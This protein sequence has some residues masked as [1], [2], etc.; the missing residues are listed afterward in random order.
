[1][2]S[3][4]RAAQVKEKFGGLRFYMTSGTDEIYNLI[5]EAEAKSR[6]TCEECGKPGEERSMPWIRTLCD[7]C[8]ENWGEIRKKRWEKCKSVT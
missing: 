7:S 6:E 3:H 8:Y 4:P 2:S 5:S 1:V